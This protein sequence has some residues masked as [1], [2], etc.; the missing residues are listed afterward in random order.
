MR[1]RLPAYALGGVLL[2][3]GAAALAQAEAER[4]LDAA[5]E[6]LRA[7]LPPEMRLEI[8]GRQV[9]PVTGRA[10]LSGVVLTDG[11]GRLEVPELRLADVTETRLGRAEAL[12]VTLRT[13]EGGTGEVARLLVAGLPVPVEGKS[14]NLQNITL[15]ALEVEA[16]RIQDPAQG[17]VS[18]ERLTLREL[19][20]DGVASAAAS[21]F[22]FRG[23][24]QDPQEARLGRIELEAV[25]LPVDNADFA[26]QKFRAG[27]ILIQGAQLRDPTDG[28]TL[29]LREASLRDWTPGNAMTL[30]LQGLQV[31][32]PATGYGQIEMSLGRLDVSGVDAAGTVDA[33]IG[34]LQVPDPMAGT[35]QRLSLEGLDARWDGQPVFALGRL[36]SEASLENGVA[37]GSMAAEG[38]RIIPP[39]GYADWLEMLG[40]Q[41]IAGGLE[42]RGSV[43]REGGRM[44]IA[45]IRVSWDQAAT[46]G[47]EAQV[48]GAPP[49]PEAGTAMDPAETA[50]Q[51]AAAQ[52]AGLSLSLRDHG[53]LGRVLTVQARQQRM[54]EARLREQWA[55]M[56]LAMPMPGSPP[57]GRRGAA[58]QAKGAPQAAQDPMAPIRQA[59]ASFIRQP[60]TLEITV[61]PP[62]PVAFG[63]ISAMGGDPA[64]A[65]ARLGISVVAR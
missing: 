57:P 56:A 18:L 34:G 42:I 19:R 11:K 7:A 2:V 23:T 41:E 44:E 58:P 25:T 59:V 37:R 29:G 62:K 8:G 9:D 20:P 28:V 12:R 17:A 43:P 45:P 63:E 13:P 50:M 14:L 48:D 33:V 22:A 24:Q 55:Q 64:Q 54:P 6:R 36:L 52:L 10:T 21:G 40:Y 49:A 30:A 35:P 4:R 47:I 53:L 39:R 46:L 51:F 38:L 15:D 5:I 65:I 3:A 27:R 31:A 61:R 1:H 16:A 26:P 60:G 32:A